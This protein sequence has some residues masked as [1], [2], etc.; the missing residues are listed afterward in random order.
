MSR[1]LLV[2]GS[3]QLGTEIRRRWTEYDVVAPPHGDLDLEDTGALTEAI[4]R[5]RAR[6]RR[7]LRGLS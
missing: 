2:G 7:Q 6:R 4:A 1:A 5:R 3:G